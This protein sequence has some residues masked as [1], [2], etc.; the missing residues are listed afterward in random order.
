MITGKQ[1][2]FL[3][4]LAH[5]LEPLVFIGKNGITE[6]VKN[7][8][9]TILENRELVKVKLQEGCIL[10]P[11]ETANQLAE[12]LGAEFVQAIGR[13]FTLYRESKENKQIVLPKAK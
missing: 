2:S 1:R 8:L 6:N 7:E 13:K 5:E 12:E 3:K 4:G 11:K 10:D 9:D